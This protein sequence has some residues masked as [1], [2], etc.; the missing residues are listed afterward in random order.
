MEHFIAGFA[1]VDGHPNCPGREL[2]VEQS[3]IDP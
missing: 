1:F 2:L 3:W